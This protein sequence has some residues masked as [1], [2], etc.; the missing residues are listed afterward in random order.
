[1]P[2]LQVAS[3]LRC[4]ATKVVQAIDSRTEFVCVGMGI[5]LG[6]RDRGVTK[7][8]LNL[9][10]VDFVHMQQGRKGMTQLVRADLVFANSSFAHMLPDY[11]YYAAAGQATAVAVK[12]YRFRITSSRTHLQVSIERA[13]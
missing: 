7:E 4:G 11:V 8:T 2:R 6:A 13:H 10:Y 1:M 9:Q 5:N 12:K 3:T